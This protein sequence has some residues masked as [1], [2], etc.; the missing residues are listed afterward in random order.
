MPGGLNK[1]KG[2]WI[3]KS[4][5]Q[6]GE[7]MG[8]KK[9]F[10]VT[11]V[12]CAFLIAVAQT[13]Y[14]AD[15]MGKVGKAFEISATGLAEWM[16]NLEYNSA[17]DEFLVLWYASGPREEEGES[18]FSFHGQ[19]IATNGKLLGEQFAPID[20]LGNRVGILPTPAFN[21]FTNNYMVAYNQ[22]QEGTGIDTLITI[23]NNLGEIELDPIAMSDDPSNQMHPAIVFNTKKREYFVAYND[24]RYGDA[25]IFG[26]ILGEDGSIVKPEFIVNSAE[27]GQINPHACY[28]PTDDTYLVNWEDFRHVE[29]WMANSDMYGALLDSDGTVKV[30][31]IPMRDDF[32]TDDEGDQRHNNIAYNPDKNEFLVSWSDNG[33]PSLQNGGAVGRIVYAD[34]TLADSEIIISDEA[35]FQMFPHLVFVEEKQMYF[36]LWEDGRNN[37]SP[38]E[39][40]WRD[41]TNWDVY[42]GW[43]D[44]EGVRVGE[45]IP[46]CVKEGIQRYSKASYSPEADTFLIVWQDVVEESGWGEGGE[47]HVTEE[48]GDI[49]GSI[50]DVSPASCLIETVVKDQDI[51]SMLRAFRDDVMNKSPEGRK[52]I[53]LYYKW[54]PT[55]VKMIG[56]D[57]KF[58]REIKASITDFL[59]LISLK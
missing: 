31:D 35:G 55:I 9:L 16:P 39:I 47:Q 40:Y 12:A 10:S 32:G 43:L 20:Y 44:P 14:A 46:A 41:A 33:R 51:L 8:K 2:Q 56:E 21:P 13:S 22:G 19:R 37:E 11:L 50:Y 48:G 27:G 45:D 29:D 30:N 38:N 18:L 1:K 42:A 25:N 52:L 54:S 15:T 6:K 57:T 23:I 58:R 5:F 24:S 4:H 59:P 49:M 28:N 34:G 53:E 17:D 3:T 7:L 36:A 26:V